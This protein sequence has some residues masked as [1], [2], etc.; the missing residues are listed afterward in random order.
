MTIQSLATYALLGRS[1]LRVSPLCLGAMTFGTDWGW[2]APRETVF[3]L[4]DTYVAAGGNFVDTADLYTNG[5]SERLIGDW[6]R[7]RNNR[8]SVVLATK[9]TFA[10]RR[11]D[12]NAGGNSRKAL[13]AALDASLKRLGTDYV[14]LYWLHCWDT[15]TPVEEVVR[16]LDEVVAAGKVRYVGFSDTPAWYAARA[17]T[18]ADERDREK[19]CAL[20]LEY[21]L[22]ERSIEREHVP[23]ALELGLAITP[24]S[25]L[26]RGMLTGK[27][28]RGFQGGEGRLSNQGLVKSPLYAKLD[29][30]KNWATLDTL[31]AV[32]HELGRSPAQVAL[33]WVAGRAGVGSTIVGATKIGQLE[34][35]LRALEAPLP[36]DAVERLEAASRIELGFPYEWFQ[37]GPNAG[38]SGNTKIL[39]EP[40]NW[41]RGHRT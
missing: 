22:I 37:N 29:S 35:N 10:G 21:S 24:W 3:A 2:G 6:F 28:T 15:V 23:L 32:G 5:T 14:D 39:A 8:D 33:A 31:I 40:P 20:Q 18:L 25:P 36:N 41:R 34:D 27:F 1:G 30:E 19:I 16:A 13:K 4:L 26:G 12:P 9:Y 7:E 11:G 38:M 17:W